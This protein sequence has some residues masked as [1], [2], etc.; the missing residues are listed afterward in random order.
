M[1]TD[2]SIL[3]KTGHFYFALTR[4]IGFATDSWIPESAGNFR[5]KSC[6][7]YIE[8][9]PSHQ[10]PINGFT[11]PVEYRQKDVRYPFSRFR[12]PHSHDCPE[13]AALTRHWPTCRCDRSDKYRVLC[14]TR[15]IRA[16][17]AISAIVPVRGVRTGES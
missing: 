6:D 4:N 11:R 5:D 1:E 7:S 17:P 15:G 14:D 3:R 9:D 13:T 12:M 8:F 2:I 16:A 10:G